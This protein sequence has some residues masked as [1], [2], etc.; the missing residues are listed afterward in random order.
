MLTI[1]AD[2]ASWNPADVTAW[3]ATVNDDDRVTDEEYAQ[4]RKAVRDALLDERSHRCGQQ[5]P[6]NPRS[7]CVRPGGHTGFHKLSSGQRWPNRAL[8]PRPPVEA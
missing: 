6:A 1:P 2:L 5:Y 4:A 3:L 7:A 8:A